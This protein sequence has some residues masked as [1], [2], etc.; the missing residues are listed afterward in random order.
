MYRD[1][2]P[3]PSPDIENSFQRFDDFLAS[4]EG[5]KLSAVAKEIVGA[6]AK[7]QKN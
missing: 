1:Q 2:L 5:K 6:R 7:R 3:K 4:R